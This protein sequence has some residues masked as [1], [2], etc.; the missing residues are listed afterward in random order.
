MELRIALKTPPSFPLL[1]LF[2]SPFPPLFFEGM[3]GGG[4]LE[5]AVG[6][7]CGSLASSRDSSISVVSPSPLLL[8]LLLLSRTSTFS[9]PYWNWLSAENR[10]LCL[11]G[12]EVHSSKSSPPIFAHKK[13]CLPPPPL[14]SQSSRD[15]VAIR[16]LFKIKAPH[17]K[18]C[19]SKKGRRKKAVIFNGTSKKGTLMRKIG[20]RQLQESVTN[21]DLSTLD[22]SRGIM[23]GHHP[24]CL[25]FA[26]AP[27]SW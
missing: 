15:E 25:S 10:S 2:L 8:L 18:V 19:S 17:S 16:V 11:Q 24:L 14:I 4:R 23:V 7:S 13:P 9:L 3:K 1:S 6:L 20:G 22:Q 12:A 27:E 21:V 26:D 5:F